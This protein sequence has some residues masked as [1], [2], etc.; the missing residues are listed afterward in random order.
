MFNIK[1]PLENIQFKD[2]FKNIKAINGNYIVNIQSSNNG[3]GTHWT[4]LIM[5]SKLSIYYDP[6][7]LQPPQ[8]IVEFGRR[9]GRK[10]IY[11]SDQIQHKDSVFCGWFSLFLLYFITVLNSSN[12]H[13]RK[14]LNLHNQLFDLIKKQTND[15]K[16]QGLFSKLVK[17]T[18]NI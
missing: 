15:D 5:T 7:G 12:K 17:Q 6:F 16:L 4:A 2:K 14:L 9:N 8:E 1:L 10:M 18:E 13:Y 11:S 3:G